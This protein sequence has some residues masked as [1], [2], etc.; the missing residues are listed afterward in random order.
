MRSH[1]R[2]SDRPTDPRAAGRAAARLV[3][4]V[5]AAALL[6]TLPVL[7]LPVP[8]AHAVAPEVQVAPLDGVEAGALS[9]LREEG[10][11]GPVA[12]QRAEDAPAVTETAPEALTA[13]TE[14]ERFDLLAV[15]WDHDLP[16]DETPV[17]QV[18]VREDEGWSEWQ[19]LPAEDGGPDPGTEEHARSRGG[20]APLLTS[21]ADA[22]QVRLDTPA[23]ELPDDV[24][25]QLVDA[26]RSAHDAHLDAPAPAATAD[27]AV[28][29]PAIISRAQWGA[30]ESLRG[31]IT[32]TSTVK[33][34]VVHHTA[35]TNSYGSGDAAAQVRAIYAYHTRTLGWSDV[36]Y[37]FLVDKFGRVYEGRAGGVHRPV[38]GAHSGGFNKDTFGVSALGTYSSTT[39]PAAMVS[40]ISRVIAWKLA[41]HDVDP[42]GTSRLTS[43]GGGTARWPAGTEVTLPN[44]IGHR[45]TGSTSCPGDALYSTMG[46]IRAEAE[47]AIGAGFVAPSMEITDASVRFESGV[48]RTQ[49]WSVAITD[50]AGVTVRSATGSTGARIDVTLPRT[51]PSGGPL[52]PGR[53]TVQATTWAGSSQGHPFSRTF[54]VERRSIIGAVSSS[55]G[56]MVVAEAAGDGAVSVRNRDYRGAWT[57]GTVRLGGEAVGAP[58]LVLLRDTRV[59][60]AV[61]GTNGYA[62]TA[63]RAADGRWSSWRNT[64]VRV[65][66]A[67]ALLA[68]TDGTVE[69]AA[70]STTGGLATWTSADHVS[71]R[72]AGGPGGGVQ[73]G[74]G[75]GLVQTAD[76]AVH[77]AVIGTDRQVWLS[78][79]VGTR[80]NGWRAV[81]GALVDGVSTST[82]DGRTVWLSSLGTNG[83]PYVQALIGGARGSWSRVGTPVLG[84]APA[85]A[86]TPNGRG[87]LASTD[88]GGDT[89]LST[90]S[91]RWGSW[92]PAG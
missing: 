25:V 44:V 91:G 10:D 77:V 8:A 53:Y 14:A 56:A 15:T 82:L 42:S 87:A 4:G 32:Y 52:P 65:T 57:G 49:G 50:P 27:A 26:G 46:Q 22:Y 18:R 79:R 55:S 1:R 89:V 45:Q 16:A 41:L 68:R 17:V 5:A 74:T 63:T 6:V 86:A 9:D 43:A 69:M 71:W 11:P 39:P 62:Y 48:Q 58:A 40:S 30:D 13:P 70:R 29:Q 75:V 67:P 54:D 34:G 60:A 85:L 59:V 36:G 23:G 76:G 92:T 47:A 38:M 3:A 72:A 64:Y 90:W 21:G 35:S 61:Q 33:V 73:P 31:S 37:N 24:Q 84:Q 83:A 81:G 19:L 12:D 88:L 66:G 20:S 80:W 51:I 2:P 7:T 78:T 28:S